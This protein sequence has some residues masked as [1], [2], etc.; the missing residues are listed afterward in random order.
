MV[1]EKIMVKSEQ[2]RHLKEICET[3]KVPFDLIDFNALVDEK[4]QYDENKNLLMP[5]IEGLSV[6]T[7]QKHKDKVETDLGRKGTIKGEKE[8]IAKAE[9]EQLK[10]EAENSNKEF[11]K[12]INAIKFATTNELDSYYK[13]MT[14][15]VET[16][17]KAKKISGLVCL[18]GSGLGKS[19]NTIKALSD[20]GLKKGEDYEILS[21]WVTPMELYKFLYENRAKDKITILD[22]VS[23]IFANKINIGIILSALWGE[24]KRIVHYHSSSAKLEV[25]TSFIY[26]GKMVWC[27]NELPKDLESVK[28]RC[29]FYE[30]KFTYAEKIKLLYEIAKLQEIPLEI[31][32]FLKENTDENTP[33]F[34]FRLLW[35]V[36][37]I[38]KANKDEWKEIA[39]VGLCKDEKIILLKQLLKECNSVAEIEKRW[40]AE[41]Q[42]CRKSFYNYKQ[43]LESK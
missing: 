1:N 11:E 2:I 15:L 9:L 10:L 38:F 14:K 32:D 24:G 31:V 33:N 43:K 26:E 39:V 8:A 17:I 35:K 25:P 7:E 16:L 20:L 22:D 37:E 42:M 28:S 4:L 3:Y 13:I 19:F 23:G 34:D 5:L 18:G 12:S 6:N 40:C 29:F 30:L 27:V 21:S 41:T 36:Y